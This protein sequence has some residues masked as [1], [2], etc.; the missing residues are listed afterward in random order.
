MRVRIA[1]DTTYRY[2]R[3]VRALVQALRLTPRDH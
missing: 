3:P 2:E 1:H